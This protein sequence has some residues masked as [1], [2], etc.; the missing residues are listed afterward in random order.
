MVED[1]WYSI[2]CLNLLAMIHRTC[3]SLL[4]NERGDISNNASYYQELGLWL[5]SI[6][7]PIAKSD[8]SWHPKSFTIL[9]KGS[10]RHCVMAIWGDF[11]WILLSIDCLYVPVL[12]QLT[13]PPLLT[14][15]KKFNVGIEVMAKSDTLRIPD[16]KGISNVRKERWKCDAR[17]LGI[18][19]PSSVGMV[20]IPTPLALANFEPPNTPHGGGI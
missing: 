13:Y 9:K 15:R 18:K 5:G 3:W 14:T 19:Y 1:H 2:A 12:N 7:S 10:E 11:L 8:S 16:A 4:N 6:P 20:N 17:G